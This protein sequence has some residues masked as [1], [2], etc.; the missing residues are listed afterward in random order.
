MTFPSSLDPQ[1]LHSL[2]IMDI[3]ARFWEVERYDASK[4]LYICLRIVDDL[5]DNHKS[6]HEKI[7]VEEFKKFLETSVDW[8]SAV[9]NSAFENA[10][11][12]KFGEMITRFKVPNW[13]WEDFSKSM[14]FDLQND[15]F[16]TYSEFLE[17]AEG[18]S[19][20]PGTIFAHLC[21]LIKE[22]GEYRLPLYDIREAARPTAIFSYIVHIIRDFQKDQLNSLNYFALDLIT[23]HGLTLSALK[24][25]AISEK[26]TPQF[27]ELMKEY[28]EFALYYQNESRRSING[29]KSQMAERYQLSLEIVHNLYSL[30]LEK[31]DIDFG[32][33]TTQELCP[34]S[35][36]IKSRMDQILETFQ[37]INKAVHL[38]K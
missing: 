15:S 6:G 10:I 3:A 12:T 35:E 22:N 36:E 19:V 21:G 5:V 14:V 2:S 28:Y 37:P 38:S 17:Y 25:I 18:A 24:E 30:I 29:I 34:T 33:F 7:D 16:S 27:R 23:K 4:L 11:K 8:K 26:P 31:V 20:A 13:I 9:Q 32:K 1:D